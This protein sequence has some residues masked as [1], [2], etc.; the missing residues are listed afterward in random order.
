VKKIAFVLI[1]S[2]LMVC[3]QAY[4]AG[5][6][7]ELSPLPKEINVA[8]MAPLL[9][10]GDM[11]WISSHKDGRLKQATIMAIAQAPLEATWEALT[12]YDHYIDY[13]PNAKSITVVSRTGND[14][15]IKYVISLPVSNFKYTLR[16]RHTYPLRIDS[17]PEDDKGD[18]KTGAWRWELIPLGQ[19]KT[20]IVY[21]FYTDIRES[22]WMIKF[23]LRIDPSMEHSINIATGMVTVNAMRRRAESLAK[24]EK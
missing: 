12:D 22:S 21:T 9:E 16:N 8:S 23:V 14:V 13:I 4:A 15:V 19:N 6:K 5:R 11:M 3:S 24:Q 17:W 20:I 10:K 1:V 18:I 7:V 2:S